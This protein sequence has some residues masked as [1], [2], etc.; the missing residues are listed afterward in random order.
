[1]RILYQC[2][3]SYVS[4]M[5][6]VELA[7]IRGLAARGH[8]VHCLVNGWNDGDFIDRLEE[9]GIPYSTAHVGKITVSIR[10]RHLKWTVDLLLHLW[11]ARKTVRRLVEEFAP[12]VIVGCNR[13]TFLLLGDLF[14]PRPT[15]FHVH[16]APRNRGAGRLAM[17]MLARGGY[18]LVCVSAFI[19]AKLIALGVDQSNIFV[20]HNGTPP[21]EIEESN[22]NAPFTVGICGQIIPCKGHED[23]IEALAM[24]GARGIA[25]RCLVY[26]KGDT[27]YERYLRRRTTELGV[28]DMFEWRGFVQDQDAIYRDLSVLVQPSR[29]EEPFGMGAVEAGARGLATI[30]TR[31]GG[32]PEVIIDDVTGYLVAPRCP[33][34]LAKRLAELA[35]DEVRRRDM[36][37]AAY[38]RTMHL[39]TTERMINQ[40]ER[41]L[42]GLLEK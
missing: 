1:M 29:S 20:V 28:A 36:G 13:D 9:A 5:E 42:Q 15:V 35:T 32:V 7:I 27:D 33:A 12:E 3:A 41:I 22:A 40:H 17:S 21:K 10:P 37:Q 11:K 25:F 26:G 8:E 16:E 4:G 23:L 14:A 2:G 6:I 18:V 19:K 39:F 38:R 30:A 34:V 31:T 24:L